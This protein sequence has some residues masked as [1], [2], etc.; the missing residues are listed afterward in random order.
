[1]ALVGEQKLILSTLLTNLNKGANVTRML[2]LLYSL[3]LF[4]QKHFL[5]VYKKIIIT[6]QFHVKNILLQF[7]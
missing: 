5:R 6:K 3:I 1:M 7:K 2:S 4:I